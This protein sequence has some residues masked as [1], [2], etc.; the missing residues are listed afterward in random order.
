MVRDFANT[1]VLP[2]VI[3]HT[4]HRV[5]TLCSSGVRCFVCEHLMDIVAD[6]DV[7]IVYY[8][9]PACHACQPYVWLDPD[10]SAKSV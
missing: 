9:C 1:R 10:F 5:F 6:D 7:H 8:E 4:V 3:H 2:I